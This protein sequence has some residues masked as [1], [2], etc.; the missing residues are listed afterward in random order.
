MRHFFPL[1]VA[2][3]RDSTPSSD[4]FIRFLANF[5]RSTSKNERNR[6]EGDTAVSLGDRGRG[7]GGGGVVREKGRDG[8][9]KCTFLAIGFC[10]HLP[11]P[12]RNHQPTH[13]HYN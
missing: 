8:E 1:F 2:P 4:D 7:G 9:D 12:A 13:P 10:P 5:D 11:P 6:G 3:K